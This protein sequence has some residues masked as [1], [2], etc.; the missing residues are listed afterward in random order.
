MAYIALIPQHPLFPEEHLT[1]VYLNSPNVSM[2]HDEVRAAEALTKLINFVPLED[3]TLWFV[4]EGYEL[5]AYK[6]MVA[7]GSVSP[8]IQN[9]RDIAER[10]GLNKSLYG[11]WR[12]HITGQQGS[13]REVN[14]VVPFNHARL[15]M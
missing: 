3:D 1:L 5:F 14:E 10:L 9:F 7:T 12:P 2:S 6:T 15:K 4:V 13:W 8:A 11:P